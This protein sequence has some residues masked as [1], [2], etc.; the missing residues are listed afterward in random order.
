MRVQLDPGLFES[1]STFRQLDRIFEF[2]EEKWHQLDTEQIDSVFESTWLQEHSRTTIAIREWLEK[3]FTHGDLTEPHPIV[4]TV[5]PCMG[6]LDRANQTV[7]VDQVHHVLNRPASIVVENQFSDG[8]FLRCVLKAYGAWDK[9][10]AFF[11]HR[12]IQWEHAGGSGQM[13]GIVEHILEDDAVL[14][15][16]ILVIRDSDRESSGT[17]TEK[18]TEINRLREICDAKQVEMH[19]L[20]KRDSENYLPVRLLPSRPVRSPA[21]DGLSYAQLAQADRDVVDMKTLFGKRVGEKF[22][23]AIHR[24]EFEDLCETC[25][26]ELRNL[27]QKMLDLR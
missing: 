19:V 20:H 3:L 11:T 26:G 1:P 17:P 22:S 23:E 27:V 9:L 25:P 2:F 21:Q 4:L 12:R 8:R 10:E 15:Q 16:R 5:A 18:Q 7:G 24:D 6:Q 13:K 14:P